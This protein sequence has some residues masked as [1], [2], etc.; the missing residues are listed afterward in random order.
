MSG[1]VLAA[2]VM[3]ELSQQGRFP[4]K[5]LAEQELAGCRLLS[6]SEMSRGRKGREP[7][8]PPRP[9]SS[10]S[11]GGG[12]D[13]PKRAPLLWERLHSPGVRV[14]HWHLRR[15]GKDP[16]DKHPGA[17]GTEEPSVAKHWQKRG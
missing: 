13:S 16:E 5:P 10:Q 14:M 6:G 7:K 11:H 2:P 12:V 15:V 3:L 1:L 9:S 8:T 4:R 17:E